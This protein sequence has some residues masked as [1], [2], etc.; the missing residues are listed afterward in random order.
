MK[1][2]SSMKRKSSDIEEGTRTLSDKDIKTTSFK[3]RRSFIRSLGVIG[4][5]ATAVALN[6]ERA[7]ARDPQPRNDADSGPYRL[8]DRKKAADRD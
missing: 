4:L 8:P 2:E 3:G 1:R 7:I 6:A 5:G